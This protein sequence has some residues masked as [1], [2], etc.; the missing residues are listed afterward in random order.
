LQNGVAIFSLT[1]IGLSVIAIIIIMFL[2]GGGLRKPTP[3]QLFVSDFPLFALPLGALGIIALFVMGA[4]ERRRHNSRQ[5][6]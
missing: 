1:L 5:T 2:G 6:K 4:A 3:L